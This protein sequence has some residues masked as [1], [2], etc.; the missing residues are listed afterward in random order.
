VTRCAAAPARAR[1]RAPAAIARC[2]VR[3]P[4]RAR[5]TTVTRAARRSATG[6]GS[7]SR[8]EPSVSWPGESPPHRRRAWYCAARLGERR[9][10]G[11]PVQLELESVRVRVRVRWNDSNAHPRKAALV[12]QKTRNGTMWCG[13]CSLLGL[14][15]S[16]AD[17]RDDANVTLSVSATQGDSAQSADSSASNDVTG[18]SGSTATGSTSTSVT[19]ATDPSADGASVEGSS[20]TSGIPAEPSHEYCSTFADAEDCEAIAWSDPPAYCIWRD[21][22]TVLGEQTCEQVVHEFR[23]VLG[24]GQGAGCSPNCGPPDYGLIWWNEASP[25][26]FEIAGGCDVIPANPW[27]QCT[28]ELVGCE[29]GCEVDCG[30]PFC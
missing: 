26:V 29:C 21:V 2:R 25:G 12:L 5:S 19:N 27:Q 16:C 6:P 4:A 9:G 18:V 30:R 14:L 7:A 23:C 10:A 28:P 11:R 8:G 13:L 3:A 24:V 17:Q 15:S 1:C 20:S 22:V